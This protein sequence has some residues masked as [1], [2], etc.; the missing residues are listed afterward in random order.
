MFSRAALN[1]FVSA[2]IGL[3]GGGPAGAGGGALTGDAAALVFGFAAGLVF[4]VSL[5]GVTVIS[6]SVAWP[7]AHS[8]AAC[9]A[10]AV[11][12]T[13]RIRL[14]GVR[15]V[16]SPDAGERE[17]RMLRGC[18][19]QTASEVCRWRSARLKSTRAIRERYR[20]A[21]HWPQSFPEDHPNWERNQF[22]HDERASGARQPAQG[23]G[24]VE[25]LGLPWRALIVDGGKQID[26]GGVR[27][28]VGVNVPKRTNELRRKH[29]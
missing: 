15:I 11:E 26:I 20:Q 25:V 2:T 9:T 17:N 5:G 18:G 16:G 27:V 7:R 22:G 28:P 4:G 12:A 29:Y 14:M 23:T 8:S 1:A 6:G 21:L 13:N 10:S 19:T 3:S 24:S